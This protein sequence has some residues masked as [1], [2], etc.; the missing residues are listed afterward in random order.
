MSLKKGTNER[1][2]DTT[3]VEKKRKNLV[4]KRNERKRV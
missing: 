4:Q 3:R 2:G 1:K